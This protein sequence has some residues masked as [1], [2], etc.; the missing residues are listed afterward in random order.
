MPWEEASP[1]IH[2][3]MVPW[4]IIWSW[5]CRRAAALGVSTRWICTPQLIPGCPSGISQG[6]SHHLPL[7]LPLRGCR[8]WDH[9]SQEADQIQS[10]S[11]KWS[12]SLGSWS[13]SVA[14]NARTFGV[15]VLWSIIFSADSLWTLFLVSYLLSPQVPAFHVPHSAPFFPPKVLAILSLKLPNWIT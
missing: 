12:E 3:F 13:C 11:L 6:F 7:D 4:Q 2:C 5:L 1:A 15:F 8:G 9:G 14:G 10:L